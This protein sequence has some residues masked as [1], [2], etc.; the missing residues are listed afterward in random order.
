VIEPIRRGVLD[1]RLRGYDDGISSVIA[2]E[3]KQSREPQGGPSLA[4]LRRTSHRYAM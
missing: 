4:E 1:T 3:A 2:S